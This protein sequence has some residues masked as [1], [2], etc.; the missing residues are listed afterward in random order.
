LDHFRLNTVVS[1]KNLPSLELALLAGTANW[2]LMVFKIFI[3]SSPEPPMVFLAGMDFF[4]LSCMR[5][6]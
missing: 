1:D 6:S 4:M 3:F 2:N 5:L